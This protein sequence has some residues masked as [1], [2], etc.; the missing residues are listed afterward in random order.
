MIFASFYF[1]FYIV[2]VCL[3]QIVIRRIRKRDWVC[4]LDT[5]PGAK[6]RLDGRVPLSQNCLQL[7]SV[8]CRLLG[9]AVDSLKFS[10]SKKVRTFVVNS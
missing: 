4:R 2:Y 3:S 1:C 10:T 8:N 9:G 5:P 7:S 6:I